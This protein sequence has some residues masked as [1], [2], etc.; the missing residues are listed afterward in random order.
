MLDKINLTIRVS[1]LH[2]LSFKLFLLYLLT[3]FSISD[4]PLLYN[5]SK[6]LF[7]V[8]AF[9]TFLYLLKKEIKIT[10]FY[11]SFFFILLWFCGSLL[12][13]ADFNSGLKRSLTLINLFI[14]NVLIY[15]I[16]Y[17]KKH[18][19]TAI[20]YIIYGGVLMCF[21]AFLMTGPQGILIAITK[22]VRLGGEIS[23]ENVF[24]FYA[25]VTAVLCIFYAYIY[26]KRMYIL[27]AF[28]PIFFSMMSGSKKAF[29]II[30]VGV[31]LINYF[32]S[33][34]KKF[35]K[36]LI[37][38][39][40]IIGVGY[41][42]FY[43]P[44]FNIVTSRITE[45]WIYTFGDS[46]TIDKSTFYRQVMIEGGLELFKNNPIVGYGISNYGY[47]FQRLTGYNFSYAHNNYIEILVNNG[48]IGFLLYYSLF[49]YNLKHLLKPAL[50]RDF[51]A[52]ALIILLISI[53][54]ADIGAINYY[55]KFTHIVI[56]LCFAYVRI[57]KSMGI[58]E[59]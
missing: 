9:F 7:I 13:A 47:Y 38:L 22:G 4:H 32:N 49:I 26:K 1:K 57:I 6:L 27:L 5:F 37:G 10:P 14:M 35:G 15:E 28:I 55:D 43:I 48:I 46:S 21:V 50:K 30:I 36:Q 51:T 12:W 3:V 42:A 34:G 31:L 11:I 29:L 18:V 20:K 59:R 23:Q 45:F 24:G 56:T 52:Q 16:L 40:L 39:F 2:L 25:A 44:A 54:V 33:E 53:L 41:I 19:D 8:L 17:T 58:T